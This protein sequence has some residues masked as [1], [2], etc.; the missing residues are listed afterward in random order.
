MKLTSRHRRT[1]RTAAVASLAVALAVGLSAC[2]TDDSEGSAASGSEEA[3]AGAEATPEAEQADAAASGPFGEACSAVPSQGPGSVRSMQS[4]PVATAASENPLLQTLVTAVGEAG[5]VQ[6]LDDADALTVFAP[7]DD[8][9]A[10]IPESD[11]DAVLADKEKLTKVLTHHVVAGQLGPDEVAGEHETLNGDTITVKG[12]GEM[13]TV[14][15][16][17]ATVLCGNVPTANAT[18]YVVDTVLMP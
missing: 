2:G 8:A 4:K 17:D 18:V 9:F 3:A 10:K 6:T 13:F 16:E 1:T 15:D 14:G 11:L 5:L 7:T 12:S